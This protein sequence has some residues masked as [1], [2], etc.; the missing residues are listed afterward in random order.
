VIAAMIDTI[1]NVGTFDGG[2]LV[3]DPAAFT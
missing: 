3:R 1:R 2:L